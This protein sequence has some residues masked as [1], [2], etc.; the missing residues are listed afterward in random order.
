MFDFAP[1][2]LA[3]AIGGIAFVALIGWRFLPT[4]TSLFDTEKAVEMGRYIAELRIG[5]QALEEGMMVEDLYPN[6]NEYDVHILGL[7]RRG[8]RLRGLARREEVREGD[9]LVVEGE[10]KAIEAFM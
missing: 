4:R 7:V 5:V 10:P 2:G 6:A 8:K 3:V 1:V 9:F